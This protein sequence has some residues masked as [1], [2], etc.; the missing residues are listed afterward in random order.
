M[1]CGGVVADTGVLGA[2]INHASLE[3]PRGPAQGV[4]FADCS[5]VWRGAPGSESGGEFCN[6]LTG[7]PWAGYFTHLGLSFPTLTMGIIL[8]TSQ[9]AL[10]QKVK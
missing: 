3:A 6:H 8:S 9:Q 4:P 10:L 5:W 1:T 2:S 7:G